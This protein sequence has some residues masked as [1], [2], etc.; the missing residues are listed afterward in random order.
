[1]KT[2]HD[3]E[4]TAAGDLGRGVHDV[5]P[6]AITELQGDRVVAGPERLDGVPGRDRNGLQQE[7]Q[8]DG[9]RARR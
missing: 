2:E 5:T 7:Q 8:S 6:S 1:M 9:H 4:R 3:G